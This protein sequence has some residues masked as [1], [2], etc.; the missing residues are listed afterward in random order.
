MPVVCVL[1]PCSKWR[2]SWRRLREA[3]ESEGFGFDAWG[4]EYG[5]LDEEFS[6]FLAAIDEFQNQN[7]R[8]PIVVAMPPRD[9]SAIW[10]SRSTPKAWK[11]LEA[12]LMAKGVALVKFDASWSEHSPSFASIEVDEPIPELM[13]R[14]RDGMKASRAHLIV[15]K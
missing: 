3:V 7:P 5:R 2:N 12:R 8:A 14:I 4:T 13:E 6:T 1:Y 10:V 15:E 9:I 11:E